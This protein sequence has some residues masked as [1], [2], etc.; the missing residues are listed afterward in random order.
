MASATSVY[1]VVREKL[2]ELQRQLAA[3]ENVV[4]GWKRYRNSCTSGCQCAK[5]YLN[6]KL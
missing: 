6:C 4:H 1:P 2:V 3:R 5:I